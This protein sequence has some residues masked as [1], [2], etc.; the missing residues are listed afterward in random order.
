MSTYNNSKMGHYKSESI[1]RSIIKSIVWRLSG[2]LILGFISFIFTN[3]WD[4]SLAISSSFNI[5]RLFLFYF[6]ERFWLKI[7]WGKIK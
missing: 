1:P 5:I 7:S 6:H 3:K 2:F 4:E